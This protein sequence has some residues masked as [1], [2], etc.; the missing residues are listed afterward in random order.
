M[1]VLPF[2]PVLPV[3]CSG[4]PAT[5]LGWVPVRRRVA[6]ARITIVAGYDARDLVT[7]ELYRAARIRTAVSALT[8]VDGTHSKT[9]LAVD[10]GDTQIETWRKVPGW[11]EERAPGQ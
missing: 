3:Y 1:R 8:L 4:H 11:C 7:G 10:A 6:G 9:I 2:G 5:R